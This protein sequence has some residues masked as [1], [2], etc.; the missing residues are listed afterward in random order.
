[1]FKNMLM[2]GIIRHYLFDYLLAATRLF[3]IFQ[4]ATVKDQNVN[5]IPCAFVV[6]PFFNFNPT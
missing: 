6:T 3:N 5:E 1:M 2:R 4:C